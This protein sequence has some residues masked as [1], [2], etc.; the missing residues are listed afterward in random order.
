MNT[1]ITQSDLTHE[2]ILSIDNSIKTT[3]PYCGVG[4]GVKIDNANNQ[5]IVTG[6]NHHPANFGKL[7]IKGKN[8]GKTL[9]NDKRLSQ[10]KINGATTSW[11][12]ALDYVA[13]KFTSLIEQHGKNSVAFY[14]SGQ[15]LT[16][17]YYI[18]NKLMKGFIGTG[19]I[20][21]NSRLCMSS[22]VAAHKRA[23]GEDIVPLSYSDLLKSDLLILAG[24][25]LAWCHPVTFQRIREE[26]LKRP[27]MKVIVID[28]RK[29]ASLEL[30]DLHLPIKAGCDLTL[31]N[32]LLAHLA[33]NDLV[34]LSL[35]GVKQAIEQCSEAT[36][37]INDIGL[38]PSQI[39]QFFDWYISH[40]NVVTVFSQGIN[41]SQVG[42][43]QGNAIINCH[44][45]S[46][47][48]GR[49]GCGPFS[50][51]G[52]P[53]AMGGREVGA[54]ANTLAGH[55]E[56]D[57]TELIDA[58]G[59][60]WETDNVA[61]Q[62]GL[63][64]VDLYKAV[65]TGEVK[66]IWIMATNPVVSMP[67][68][69]QIAR[70]LT[71]C[72]MVVVSDCVANNDTI[73]LANVVLPAQGWGE[74]SGTVTNSERR[75]SRQ[76]SFLEPFGESKPDWWILCEVAKRMGF[77]HAFSYDGPADIFREHAALS[78]LNNNGTRAFDI[79]AFDQITTTQYDQW[80]PKQW[81]QPKGEPIRLTDHR[82]F[83]EGKYFHKTNNVKVVT[84]AEL[85][86]IPSDSSLLLNTGRNRDQW[87]TQTRTG[88]AAQLTNRHPEPI[89]D[90]HPVN[91]QQAGIV[92][93]EIIQI[94]NNIE[95]NDETL[96]IRCHV[97]DEVRVGE[98]F[99]PIHWS[100]DNANHGSVSKLIKSIV[101]PISGQPAF[102][103]TA[104][105]ISKLDYQSEALLLVKEELD[106]SL[107]S[108]DLARY[109]ITQNLADGYCYHIASTLAPSAL[110]EQLLVLLT[111][112]I[113]TLLKRTHEDYYQAGYLEKDSMQAGCFVSSSKSLLPA[114]WTSHFFNP[115]KFDS[116][117][118]EFLHQ[119]ASDVVGKTTFC[120]CLNVNRDSVKEAID[121]GS[122]TVQEI[123]E[124]TGA[125]NGCGSCIDDI[126][127]QLNLEQ[128]SQLIV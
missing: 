45:A 53:N 124:K 111:S 54:L 71:K 20:D 66:A 79:S 64:A 30:A 56:F 95:N 102:K 28:P 123:K 48:I 4:C 74:K 99:V 82:F 38:T 97:T 117:K 103:Q 46:G 125:G 118:R 89:V 110:Y 83:E 78:G 77:A 33:Q 73:A 40:D 62:G 50:I 47:K 19:N 36:N 35:D 16:E 21:T 122:L 55:I 52:Q 86:L 72:D 58:L 27:E 85:P 23:F 116:V 120:Q 76:R 113:G 41:Q 2:S 31:F 127:T 112:N 88:K 108:V 43:D 14:V 105:T 90:I 67:N 96:H 109:Q 37:K 7:C 63:K 59:K 121:S 65:E 51:T 107:L 91:A 70:A 8:L 9:S 1:S 42:T 6:D 80:I 81:P 115:A 94:E 100:K 128:T 61:T 13:S 10:P 25:N 18:A 57:D 104:V 26:K 69:Q 39:E 5:A 126:L 11:P 24:S 84:S 92:D 44:V 12:R 87:H 32:G 75:I 29:T 98:M 119:K 15:L 17:D 22:A 68:H 49:E 60:F 101:D 106:A 114:G 34:D 93:Q 3:C